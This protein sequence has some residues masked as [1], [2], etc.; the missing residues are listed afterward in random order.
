MAKKKYDENNGTG[1]RD[2]VHA[3]INFVVYSHH[4]YTFVKGGCK[5]SKG[6]KL[7]NGH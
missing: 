4:L 1:G 5:H 6:L 7:G 2:Y 3:F